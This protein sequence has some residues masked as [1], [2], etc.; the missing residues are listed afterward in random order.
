MKYI[1]TLASILFA[2][3]AALHAADSIAS[4]QT[5]AFPGAEGHGA[6][7]KGGRGGRVVHVTTLKKRGPGSL[8]W[9][10]NEVKE[11]RTIVFDV[12]GVIDCNDEIAF[13]ITPE[14]DLVTIAGET[15]PQ[16]VAVY[17]YRRFDISGEEVILRFLR[18]RGTHIHTKNDPDGL[19]IRDAKNVIVDHCSFA[20]ACDETLDTSKSERV[21]IQWCGIDASRK[22]EAHA[23][24]FENSGQWHNYGSLHSKSKR[25]TIH[26]CLYAHQAKRCPLTDDVSDVE[27]INNVIYNYSNTQQTWGAEGPGLTIVNCLFKLGP[28]RRKNAVPVNPNARIIRGCV[29]RE[30]DGRPGPPSPD[31]GPEPK[32]SLPRIDTAE[33]AYTRVLNQAGALPHDATSALMVKDTLHG[34]GRQGYEDRIAADRAALEKAAPA[35][36][37]TDQDGLPDEWERTHQLDPNQPADAAEVA[38]DGY[39]GLEHYCHQLAA[40]RIEAAWKSTP[41]QSR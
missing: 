8:A 10:I 19:L 40:R 36:P 14:N 23:D 2:P 35:L 41:R 25:I 33:D 21:T 22:A 27:A 29:S 31:Q 3:L 38:R 28:D 39:T 12:S 30:T 4:H 18:F 34:T 11:P 24:F 16:G 20:G 37:D 17:N 26:H 1:L 7:A 13:T 32:L 9:A 6:F 5:R 15:S